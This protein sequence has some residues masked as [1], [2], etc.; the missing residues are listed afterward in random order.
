M[1][2]C[3]QQGLPNMC[4]ISKAHI[5]TVVISS[6]THLSHLLSLHYLLSQHLHIGC[7]GEARSLENLFEKMPATSIRHK[8]RF[9]IIKESSD[10]TF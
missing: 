4:F 9:F 8:V 3:K 1:L 10:M 7:H 2:N 6:V 5:P